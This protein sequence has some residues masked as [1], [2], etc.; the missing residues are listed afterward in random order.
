MLPS[1]AVARAK[2]RSW[3][4]FGSEVLSDI[5]GFY[6]ARD[7]GVF[8]AKTRTL[9]ERFAQLEQH[10]GAGT[11]FAGDAFSLVD[12]TWG[13]VFRCFDTFDRIANFGI[14]NDKPRVAAWR[15]ALATR[16][17]VIAATPR[18]ITMNVCGTS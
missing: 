18:G 2:H 14:L 16:P 15:G 1:D 3:I 13:P 9:G 7:A 8:D 10:L 17:S 11:H 12:A 6:S 4:A 5:A